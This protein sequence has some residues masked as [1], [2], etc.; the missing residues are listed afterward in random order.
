M[1]NQAAEG[2]SAITAIPAR[3]IP[4]P[5]A[6]QRGGKQQEQTLALLDDQPGQIA[7]DNLGQCGDG[8]QEAQ[9]QQ[10]H[11]RSQDQFARHT[12]LF[13]RAFGVRNRSQL[14]AE[15]HNL[16]GSNRPFAARDSYEKLMLNVLI[17]WPARLFTQVR[18]NECG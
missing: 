10:F 6:S 9:A 5:N 2:C 16:S 15:S 12:A 7:T 4:A 11:R 18:W 14:T 1:N 17:Q 3:A 8:K 13:R